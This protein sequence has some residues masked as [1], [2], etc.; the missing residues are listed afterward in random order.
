MNICVV[1][2]FEGDVEEF[3]SMVAEFDE[4]INEAASTI[5][6]GVVNTNKEG[7]SKIITIANITNE[8]RFQE[9]M[10]SPKMVAWDKAHNNKDDIYSIEKIG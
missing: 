8:E 2:T 3:M 6:F 4:E 5:E 7:L 10:S 9:I 1:S